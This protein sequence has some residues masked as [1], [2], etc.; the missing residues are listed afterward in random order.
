MSTPFQSPSFNFPP[1]TPD[2]RLPPMPTDSELWSSP[3]VPAPPQ[4]YGL[5]PPIMPSPSAPFAPSPPLGT[6]TSTNGIISPLFVDRLARDMNLEPGQAKSLHEFV[7]LGS[8][9]L[10]LSTP[11]LATRLYALA[12]FYSE[13]AEKRRKDAEHIP[14][15]FPKMWRDLALRLEGNFKFTK[16][17]ERNIRGMARDI[18][19]ESSRTSYITMHMDLVNV[20]KAQAVALGMDNIIGVPA[21]EQ[22]LVSEAKNTSSSVRNM[23]RKEIVKSITP[24]TWIALADFTFNTA[25]KYKLGGAGQ[26]LSQTFTAHV[27]ILRRFAYDH[28]NLQGSSDEVSADRGADD[29]EDENT[30]PA[31]KRRKTNRVGGRIAAG[32]DF[33]GALDAYFRKEIG[34]RGKSFTAPKWKRYIDK[35]LLDDN[36]GF[37]Y[38]TPGNEVIESEFFADVPEEQVDGANGSTGPPVASGTLVIALPA[39][40]PRPRLLITLPLLQMWVPSLTVR[41][42]ICTALDMPVIGVPFGGFPGATSASTHVP[43]RLTVCPDGLPHPSC[44]PLKSVHSTTLHRTWELLQGPVA[45]ASVDA[46]KSIVD[47]ELSTDDPSTVIPDI[48]LSSRSKYNTPDVPS[49]WPMSASP[50]ALHLPATPSTGTD[51]DTPSSAMLAVQYDKLLRSAQLHTPNLTITNLWTPVHIGIVGNELADEAAKAATEMEADPSLFVS[52]TT[53][54]RMIRLQVL[55]KWRGLWD[56]SKTGQSLRA[57]D[58]SPPSLRLAAVMRTAVL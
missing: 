37:K 20:L 30:P 35:L 42:S 55:E 57:I 13:A 23:Y 47:N 4:G 45:A 39:S 22:A 14:A 15:D 24:R 10:G 44:F 29:D 49:T 51:T 56:R 48:P 31:A 5:A 16:D 58:K 38:N 6:S 2:P 28:P 26:N 7:K 12:A 41:L 33:W 54:Q 25:M 8:V 1:A 40:R 53:V 32:H 27:V 43:A 21:R 34:V 3:T 36:G 52:L 46:A 9:G 11:D 18:I 50:S 19:F 17:Q